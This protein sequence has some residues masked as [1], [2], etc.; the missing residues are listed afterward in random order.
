[1]PVVIR[2]EHLHGRADL[3]HVRQ[4]FRRVTLADHGPGPRIAEGGEHRDDGHDHQQFDQR[5]SRGRV[6]HRRDF[7]RQ[8]APKANPPHMSSAHVEGSGTVCTLAVNA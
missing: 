4:A 5:E 2:R 6:F 3:P 7:L 1:M 8:A